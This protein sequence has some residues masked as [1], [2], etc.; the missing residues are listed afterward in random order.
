MPDV[1]NEPASTRDLISRL[2]RDTTDLVRQEIQLARTEISE[3][4]G[5]AVTGLILLQVGLLTAFAALIVLLDAAVYALA[6][7]LP[8]WAAALIVGG[9]VVVVGLIIAM[10]GIRNLRTG[11]SLPTRTLVSLERDTALAG[12]SLAGEAAP[13]SATHRETTR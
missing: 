5:R 8:G 10:R 4:L 2:T 7:V 3:N 1:R 11:V 13:G 12:D 9:V 6:L